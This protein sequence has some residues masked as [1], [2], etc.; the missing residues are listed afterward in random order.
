MK[1][2]AY[3]VSAVV[4]GLGFST[5]A[6]AD[7]TVSGAGGVEV[8]SAG[9]TT[10]VYQG[11]SVTFSL[12][13]TTASGIAISTSA[14]WG[15]DSDTADYNAS[16]NGAGEFSS[17]SFAAGGNTLTLATGLE[18]PAGGGVGGV[19]KDLVS[20]GLLTQSA[21][22]GAG[23]HTGHG[24]QLATAMGAASLTIGYVWDTD[25]TAA[26]Q[27]ETTD[28]TVVNVQT[29]NSNTS[30][31]DT[32]FGVGISMPMGPL[33]VSVNHAQDNDSTTSGSE[34]GGNIAYAIGG[35]TLKVGYLD[36]TTSGAAATET[37]IAYSMSLDADTSIAAGYKST[38]EG[39]N[40]TQVTEL[41]L[42]RSMGG[43]VSVFLD[44]SS[45]S[46]STSGSGQNS[47]VAFGTNIAF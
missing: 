21:S 14:G 31:N 24:V 9:S 30:G 27:S 4:A 36:D 25:P 11:G 46:G 38:D 2:I 13:T 15:I 40:S 29:N 1:K 37:S 39:S 20:T 3:L 44:Y 43:G 33:T 12:S 6:N 22:A 42:N 16:G 8:L 32:A 26:V 41:A 17:M 10:T 19:S 34:T 7:V 35:G 18:L 23:D 47:A 45:V 5:A 28:N